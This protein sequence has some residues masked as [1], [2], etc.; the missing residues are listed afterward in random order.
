M[1][2]PPGGSRLS[3]PL[4]LACLS[5]SSIVIVD[6]TTCSLLWSMVPLFFFLVSRFTKCHLDISIKVI[7]VG[8]CYCSSFLCPKVF[9]IFTIFRNSMTQPRRI[10]YICTYIRSG[11]TNVGVFRIY[12]LT[13]PNVK[14]ICDQIPTQSNFFKQK[15]NN[16]V[17]SKCAMGMLFCG[18]SITLVGRDDRYY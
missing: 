14:S 7:I 2:A 5:S 4:V 17:K 1:A 6:S 15:M 3:L 18:N 11:F 10:L 9:I 16:D 13:Q 8:G 12:F